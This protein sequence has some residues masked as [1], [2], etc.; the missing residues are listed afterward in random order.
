M[1]LSN[2]LTLLLGDLIITV[3]NSKYFWLPIILA[4]LLYKL[5]MYYIHY[6]Y[7]VGLNWTLLEIKL[8]REIHKGPQAME[9]VLNMLHQSR[10][11]DNLIEKYK[12]GFLR[13]WFSLEIASFGGDIHFYIYTQKFFRNLVEAQIY[14]QYPDVVIEEVNDYTKNV[15]MTGL[16]ETWNCW[17]TEFTLTEADAYPIKTYVDYGLHDLATKEEQKNDPLTAILEYM[18]SIK[19]GEQVWFQILIRATT[20]KWKDEGKKLVEKIMKEKAAKPGEVNVG[21]MKLTPGERAVIEAIE[22]DVSKLGFDVGIRALYFSPKDTFDF[23]NVSS[24]VGVMKQFNALNLNGFK[25][26]NTTGAKSVIGKYFNRAKKREEGL[27]KVKMLDAYRW[28]SYFYVPY[29]RKPFVLNTEELATIYHFPGRV[30][31]TPTLS[32]IEAK[33]SEPPPNLPI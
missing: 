6:K 32:R 14:A 11:A 21:A 28:R 29:E 3:W 16:G 5:W 13:P 4:W 23:V 30:A 1:P 27:K 12:T 19:E 9:M 17:G 33:R 2:Q 8:P 7:I 10:D 15:F 26:Q 20:K 25:P 31:E 24:L 18:G 22:R